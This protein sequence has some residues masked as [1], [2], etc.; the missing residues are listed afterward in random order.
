MPL[1]VRRKRGLQSNTIP[2]HEACEEASRHVG[3]RKL[4]MHT[5]C[6]PGWSPVMTHV[7][8]EPVYTVRNMIGPGAEAAAVPA[9]TTSLAGSGSSKSTYT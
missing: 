5:H 2:G 1:L 6:V 3:L 8:A 9:D 7:L 4:T